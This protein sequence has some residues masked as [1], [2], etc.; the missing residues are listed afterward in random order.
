MYVYI[1]AEPQ[2]WTVGHYRPTSDEWVPESDWP[3]T[4]DAA[5]RVRYLNG[6]EVDSLIFEAQ[7]QPDYSEMLGRIATALETLAG[8]VNPKG[9]A[10][11]L[12]VLRTGQEYP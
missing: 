11:W 2:L 7:A 9:S 6:G 10:E 1:K 3:T 8:C 5:A 12:P 4:R